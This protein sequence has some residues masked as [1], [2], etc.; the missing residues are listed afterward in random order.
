M[1]QQLDLIARP[2]LN[3]R[4]EAGRTQPRLWVRRLVIWSGPGIVRQDEVVGDGL[5]HD[6]G[7]RFGDCLPHP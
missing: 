7:Q 1:P 5:E 6:L 2:E 4:P 3:L